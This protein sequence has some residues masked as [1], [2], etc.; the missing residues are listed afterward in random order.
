MVT[1]LVVI[2]LWMSAA[3]V[4]LATQPAAPSRLV[5]WTT[6]AMALPPPPPLPAVTPEPA[7]LSLLATRLPT[8][9]LL[10]EAAVL[11]G[12]S[13]ISLLPLQLPVPAEVA[14]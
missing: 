11:I 10:G 12:L 8:A 4:T 5:L 13:A 2:A 14:R 9:L 1:L 3:L 6:A 7:V